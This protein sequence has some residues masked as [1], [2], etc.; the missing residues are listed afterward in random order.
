MS[1]ILEGIDVSAAQGP[2]DWKTVANSGKVAYADC[3]ATEGIGYVDPQFHNNWK[4]IKDA[5][6]CRGSYDFVRLY[7]DPV[8]EANFFCSTMSDVQYDDYVAIDIES[9]NSVGPTFTHWVL[10]WLETVEK[11][12]GKIPFVYT[13]G[14]F[15]NQH[16]AGTAD[17][18]TVKK[19][20]K[21]PLWLAAYVNTPDAFVP[22]IWKSVGWTIWQRSGDITAY[23]DTP[24]RVP[25]ISTVVDRN[26]FRGSLDDF[27]K[28]ILNLQ[29]SQNN[30]FSKASDDIA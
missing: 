25:G 27:K 12:T 2:I 9:G 19:F 17:E 10:T 6:I 20:L 30:S 3:K 18:E 24:L 16:V 15:F 7:N 14:P 23:G 28:V 8:A 5:G 21:Y 1:L 26:Q 4:G 22:I 11:N 29:T 13:G